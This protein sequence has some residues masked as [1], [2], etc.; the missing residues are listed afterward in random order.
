MN[1]LQPSKPSFDFALVS[2]DQ[3]VELKAIAI[4][5]GVRV[6]R[7]AEEMLAMGA[8]LREAKRVCREDGT[9]FTAWCESSECP[10]GYKTAQRLVTVHEQIGHK[11]DPGSFFE[12]TGFKVLAAITQTREEDIRQALLEHIESEAEEGRKVTQKEITALKKALKDAQSQA[13]NLENQA[14]D[15]KSALEAEKRKREQAEKLAKEAENKKEQYIRD[16][17]NADRERKRLQERIMGQ[18]QALKDAEEVHREHLEEM[19]VRIADEESK[20]PRTDAEKAEQ[21]RVLKELRDEQARINTEINLAKKERIKVREELNDTRKELAL[22]DKV[23]NDW[24]MAAI[25]YREVALRLTGSAEA[26]KQIPLTDELY[27]QIKL[28]R[29]LTVEITHSLDEVTHVGQSP[30]L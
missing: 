16:L 18:E 17:M 1:E 7:T 11:K 28:I 13:A 10:V 19:R 9:L 30:A 15:A 24:G 2:T 8:D 12:N 23:L 25:G 21:E 20:R 27:N 14:F 6:Q 4:R 29:E 5:L 3:A 22:R 26:L